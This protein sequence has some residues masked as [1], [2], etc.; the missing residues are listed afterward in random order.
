MPR[1]PK[2]PKLDE[3]H[4]LQLFGESQLTVGC[5]AVQA[6][7]LQGTRQDVRMR[8]RG[9]CPAGS[10]VYGFLNKSGQLVYVGMSRCL[11]RR[12]MSYFHSRGGRGKKESRIGR[13]G[14]QLLWQPTVHP[15]LARLR[16][17]ELI[18]RF[19]PDWNVEGHPWRMREGYITL[20]T[21]EAPW[22]KLQQEPAKQPQRSW[23]PIPFTTRTRSAVEELNL[24]FRLRDCPPTTPMHFR[25]EAEL[26]DAAPRVTCLRAETGS[27]L[28][29]CI[30]LSSRRQYALE[31][32]R[33]RRFLDGTAPQL[34]Q[35]IE[36][37]MRQAAQSH[38]FERAARLR[39]GLQALE[40]LDYHLRRFHDWLNHAN[41][42]YP[43]LDPVT[44]QTWW[45]IV[46][47]GVIV[48]TQLAPTTAG[49]VRQVRAALRRAQEAAPGRT[50]P[51]AINHF[52]AARVVFA[53]FRRFPAERAARL[54]Y[55][56][57]REICRRIARD[58]SRRA[59]G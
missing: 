55:R 50:D 19:S 44:N 6:C 20:V 48:D 40:R 51:A 52:Q 31:L 41:F 30:G 56:E 58:T 17:L 32:G 45:L 35:E 8:I 29:P 15:L 7:G 10:G 4:W 21:H 36:H 43:A 24:L 38:R 26:L 11:Q 18:R 49:S 16:E 27:C 22:F 34:L 42:I 53:W 13:T 46:R 12:L 37:E 1:Q 25:G 5:G 2:F 57:A 59:A 39:N 14:V 3:A 47:H 33:A 9:R 54:T 23:G 28:A